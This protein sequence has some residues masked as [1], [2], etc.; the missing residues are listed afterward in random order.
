VS[1]IWERVDTALATLGVSYAQSTYISASASDIP[2][3]YLV[4]FDVSSPPEQHADDGETER[5]YRVQVSIYNRAGLN[6]LPNVDGAMVAAGFARGP[7]RELP[8]NP[9]TRHFGLA[10]EFVIL[11]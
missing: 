11:E 10:K 9:E 2:D 4:Y 5:S 7:Q 3:L 6:S 8:Y 1:T